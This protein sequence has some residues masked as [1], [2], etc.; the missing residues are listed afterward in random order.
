M[1]GEDLLKVILRKRKKVQFK[2]D[3]TILAVNALGGSK[4]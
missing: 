2:L 4:N 3:G 1:G